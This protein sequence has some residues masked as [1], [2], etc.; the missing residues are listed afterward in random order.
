M[1]EISAM[2]DNDVLDS[3][4]QMA[5]ESSK[6]LDTSRTV[7]LK[8]LSDPNIFSGFD[9]IKATLELKSDESLGRTLDLFS[10]GSFSNYKDSESNQFLSLSNAQILKLRQLTV[11]SLVKK[12]CYD[13][14]P[15]V[16]Y[17]TLSKALHLPEGDYV[18]IE[19]ILISCLDAGIISGHLCQM[20]KQF[21][22]NS[23]STTRSRDV[24]PSQTA[25][26]L[27]RLKDFNQRVEGALLDID[28][29]KVD[30]KSQQDETESF[31]KKHEANTASVSSGAHQ[32]MGDRFPT[33]S[34]RSRDRSSARA[35]NKRS[36]GGIGGGDFGRF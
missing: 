11:L 20:E 33:A 13:A 6:N 9:E 24:S 17:S 3:L 7:V 25:D 29:A 18:L 26:L 2:G 14:S 16:A 28:Q 10:F 36:R 19:E 23:T 30:L 4:L 31:W 15:I 8:A 21:I 1:N 22:L 35:S 5:K 12:S 34:F 27:Q 32:K